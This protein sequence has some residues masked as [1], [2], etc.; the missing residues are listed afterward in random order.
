MKKLFFTLLLILVI[1][2]AIS[3]TNFN[4]EKSDSVLKSKLQIYEE[5]KN[6]ISEFWQ[7]ERILVFR[8]DKE[9]GIIKFNSTLLTGKVFDDYCEYTYCY[10]ATF[11][12][13]Q[14]KY[15]II[16]DSVHCESAFNGN[17]KIKK[18]EPFDGDNCPNT[19][20]MGGGISKKKAILMMATLKN[21]LEIIFDKYIER[22]NFI[23]SVKLIDTVTTNIIKDT[24]ITL[25]KSSNN[26]SESPAFINLQK[27]VS[28]LKIDLQNQKNSINL[29]GWHLKKSSNN[30]WAYFG[31][32]VV[33]GALI[34]VGYIL[35]SNPQ[36]RQT[37]LI[38]GGVIELGGFICW[39]NHIS[40]IRKAGKMLN[41]Y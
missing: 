27:V 3:Q 34:S 22:I 6:F 7:P 36:D 40:Q 26:N 28:S 20:V 14:G 10:N 24:I 31:L 39:L 5:T 18:I 17:Y 25:N 12:I 1:S 37:Y 29:A 30:L 16:I 33:G 8:D 15:T 2:Q 23:K 35:G 19:G 21:E 13:S 41:N 9:A 32:T 4:W 11:K 38:V